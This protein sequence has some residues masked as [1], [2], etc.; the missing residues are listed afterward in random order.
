MGHVPLQQWQPRWHWKR[1]WSICHISANQIN[2][3]SCR[4]Q[5]FDTRTAQRT[6]RQRV[7]R[8]GMSALTARAMNCCDMCMQRRRGA[9]RAAGLSICG[10]HPKLPAIQVRGPGQEM[11][12][13]CLSE[14][15]SHSW[16]CHGCT[17]H[18]TG[19]PF[20]H[21]DPRKRKRKRKRERERRGERNGP[22]GG[23]RR[24]EVPPLRDVEGE[25]G[26]E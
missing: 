19:A 14:V 8:Q 5:R 26:K 4:L 25:R 12:T 3:N 10:R 9:S 20:Q 13:G 22:R 23:T 15:A 1:V 6:T 17:G 2:P 21:V 24:E 11:N 7:P 16:W 18:K